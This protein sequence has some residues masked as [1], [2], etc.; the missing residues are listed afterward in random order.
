MTCD[1][2]IRI[3]PDGRK[4]YKPKKVYETQDAAILDAKFL[5]SLKHR[6]M[7]VAPYR[8]EYCKKFHLGRNGK[9]IKDKYKEKL[10]KD[11]DVTSKQKTFKVVGWI[12]LSK[13]KDTRKKKQIT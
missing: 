9:E 8:C 4:I 12:D 1:T 10:S 6:I 5:N 3:D 11:P 13:I 7:K 2:L